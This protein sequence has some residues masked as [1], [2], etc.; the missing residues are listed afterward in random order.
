MKVKCFILC[1]VV[2]F[3]SSGLT[4]GRM[5]SKSN[6]DDQ[7][8]IKVTV[9]NNN[10]G[11]IKD[12]RKV[13]LPA[14]EGELRFMDV[15]S[16]IMPVTVHAKSLNYPEGFTVLEQNYEYDL[17]N[18][19]RLLD[20][21]VG[22]KIKI[23]EWN[24]FQDRKD[25]VE[26][27][28]LSN[29]NG[30]I[31][32]INNEIYLG[33]PGYKVLSEMPENLISK[34]TLMWLYS[35]TSS[36]AHNLEVSYLTKN[37]N[38]KADYVLIL[39]QDDTSA[40]IS[41]WVT[42]DNTSG[43]TYNNA[44]LKLVA[45]EVHRVEERFEDRAYAMETM[46]RAPVPQFEEKS[47]FEYH[48]YD[49]KR[50]TTIKNRQTKQVSLLESA[51]KK[52]QKELLVQGVGQY[53]MR[54]YREQHPRQ[55]VNVFVKFKNSKDNR[56]GMPLPAG[57]VRL[58]KEDDNGSLEFVGEDK[59]THIPRDEYVQLKIG[60]AFDVVAERIQTNYRRITSGLHESEWEI[61]LRNHKKKDVS[62][63]I[64]EPLFGNWKVL[65]ASHPYKKIDAFRIRFDVNIPQ[66]GEVK[67]RYSIRAGL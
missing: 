3:V 16:H 45:G 11:L 65:A 20:K 54:Q 40:D 58:Y 35:N 53:F 13:K 41:G 46:K 14:G 67:V 17:I 55:P 26:A 18:A 64:E 24:K 42:L 10:L 62:I 49:L 47:F 33:H 29:N 7:V 52:V 6:L 44:Q 39:N 50:K 23:I 25:V 38:W 30:Q 4:S 28:L 1:L 9:Y 22:K 32:K 51:I 21:Y 57:I 48:I 5:V 2:L 19:D 12:T 36:T 60:E 63:G 31:Y 34:P 66:D 61:I 59:I 37:I 8:A 15:A 27:I 43:A 56:L